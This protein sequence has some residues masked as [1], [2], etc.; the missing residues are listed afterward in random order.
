MTSTSL[1]SDAELNSIAQSEFSLSELTREQLLV[2]ATVQ[3]AALGML[4]V[5]QDYSCK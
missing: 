4:L 5:L 2:L 1:E 3:I